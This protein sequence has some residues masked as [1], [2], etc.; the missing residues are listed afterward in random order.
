M[1]GLIHVFM[2]YYYSR[3]FITNLYTHNYISHIYACPVNI[4]SSRCQTCMYQCV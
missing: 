3:P 1:D 2:V 4:Q